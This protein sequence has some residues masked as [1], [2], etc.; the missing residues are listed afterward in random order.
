VNKGSTRSKEFSP[1]TGIQFIT[2]ARG[3]KTAA[4]IDLKK[5]KTLWEDIED[6]LVSRSRRHEKWIP[7][8]K[9]RA[10]LTTA[11][12]RADAESLR[13]ASAKKNP[14]SASVES[15]PDNRFSFHR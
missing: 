2:D 9:V 4:I 6:V 10:D 14:R 11:V 12:I 3:R 5:H 8:S 13:Q 15:L 1:M 7:L